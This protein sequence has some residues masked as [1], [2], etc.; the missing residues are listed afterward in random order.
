[1]SFNLNFSN[2]KLKV[3]NLETRIDT[4]DLNSNNLDSLI[5]NHI[6]EITGAHIA[7][8]IELSSIPSLS[9][10]NV[11]EA[12]EEILQKINDHTNN[13]DAHIASHISADPLININETN[14][15][16]LLE[17]LEQLEITNFNTV[18]TRID[19]L[20]AA[21]ID[22]DSPVNRTFT[23]TQNAIDVLDY[24]IVA[25]KDDVADHQGLIDQI[26]TSLLNSSSNT[27]NLQ[28]EL[29]NLKTGITGFTGFVLPTSPSITPQVGSAYFSPSDD[30]LYVYTST[31]YK[32]TQ[33][34]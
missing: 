17:G 3:S 10:D 25:L 16:S 8:A 32:Y 24:D 31:G 29:N 11:Q 21:D 23:S 5:N 7:A 22:V 30:K 33:L 6:S 15:Q 2:L 18:Q 1:V 27:N 13:L 28:T 9:A 14:V 12:L 26:L 20:C 4:L 34:I 19:N